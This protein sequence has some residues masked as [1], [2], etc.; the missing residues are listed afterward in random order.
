LL[1]T[2]N[3]DENFKKKKERKK[4]VLSDTGPDPPFQVNPDPDPGF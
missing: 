2:Q 4:S 3:L 1:H